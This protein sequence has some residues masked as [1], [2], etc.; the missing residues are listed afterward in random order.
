MGE[1]LVMGMVRGGTLML[2]EYM[3]AWVCGRFLVIGLLRSFPVVPPMNIM[4][5]LEGSR[6]Q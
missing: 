4:S 1:G 3:S 5:S 6:V 2:C